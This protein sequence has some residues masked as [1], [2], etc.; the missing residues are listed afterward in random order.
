MAA[1][2]PTPSCG[3]CSTE[4]HASCCEPQDKEGCC[5]PQSTS[6]GCV[7]SVP[8]TSI[9]DVREVVRERYAVA[10]RVAAGSDEI[11][12]VEPGRG[13]GLSAGPFPR[14]APRTGHAALTAP[15]SPQ[16]PMSTA[17]LSS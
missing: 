7:A 15:G 1:P 11:G 14:P 5:T 3:C 6:C 4:Q 10:A 16:A 2:T 17:F 8:A 9:A 13:A 12:G